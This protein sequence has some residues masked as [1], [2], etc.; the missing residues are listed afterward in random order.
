MKKENKF[1]KIEIE[2]HFRDEKVVMDETRRLLK[3]T[4]KEG[5]EKRRKREQ[6]DCL[7]R[8]VGRRNVI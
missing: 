7:N 1:Y 4:T 3:K 8:G 6:K 5:K 2:N